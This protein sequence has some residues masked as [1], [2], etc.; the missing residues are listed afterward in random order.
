MSS[1]QDGK[2]ENRVFVF[3][4]QEALSHRPLATH[5]L[6]S[7]PASQDLVSDRIL[8]AP[9][10]TFNVSPLFTIKTRLRAS[11]TEHFRL[12]ILIFIPLNNFNAEILPG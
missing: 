8:S 2:E 6:G 3:K 10:L 12:Q 4:E 9:L 11:D 7:S 1:A 5:A